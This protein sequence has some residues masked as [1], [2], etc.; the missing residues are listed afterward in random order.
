MILK[1]RNYVPIAV[2][3]ILLLPLFQLVLSSFSHA[4]ESGLGY[5]SVFDAVTLQRLWNSI[6]IAFWDVC[7]SV[8]FAVPVYWVYLHTPVNWRPLFFA[9]V[10]IPF[11]FPAFATASS[12]MILLSHFEQESVTRVIWGAH[13]FWSIWLYSIPGCSFIL[14][15][16]DWS[17]LFIILAFTSRIHPTQIDSCDL[18]L[19][20]WKAVYYVI[21]PAWKLPL[22]FGTSIIFALALTHFETASLLQIDVYALEIYTRFSTLLSLH[23]TLLLCIPFLILS[24]G[25]VFLLFSI[26]RRFQQ[27]N[28]SQIQ[29]RGIPFIAL[30]VTCLVLM[31]S[32]V[33]PL[34][35]FFMQ[36]SI[37]EVFSL[38]RQQQNRIINSLVY[39]VSSS[40]FIVLFGLIFTKYLCKTQYALNAVV[41]FLFFVPGI[42]L[43]AGVLELRSWL[44]FVHP[45]WLSQ[46]TLLY[47][48]VCH[49]GLTGII[50][51]YLLWQHYGNQQMEYESL[52]D[53]PTKTKLLNLYFPSLLIPALQCIALASLLVWGDVAMTVLLH[54]P[55]GETL[56]VYYFNQ[57]HYGSDSRTAAAGML[58]MIT[59]LFTIGVV[60][61]MIRLL[62]KFNTKVA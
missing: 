7:F 49:F 4:T 34:N 51:G 14:S 60:M 22:L 46:L 41:V 5:A 38:I 56:T 54:P 32:V 58:L 47:A 48:F 26:T 43:A 20:R 9:I 37:V 13:S 39:S 15:L 25:I 59:P 18:Y 33:I 12:W 8:L 17:I 3:V 45:G 62:Q 2:C 23:E 31:F 10:L 30:L 52:L 57:L 27:G 35:G 44:P 50:A 29:L 36:T 16:H 61:G 53:L 1:Q 55:G 19:S 42:L 21:L 40:V 24:M 28:N 11:T 6:Q